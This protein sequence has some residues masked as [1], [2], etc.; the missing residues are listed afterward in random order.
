[1]YHV[2][3]RML[4]IR[5]SY[6]IAEIIIGTI[7]TSQLAGLSV[8]RFFQDFGRECATST[9]N[10]PHLPKS[11]NC[12]P[13]NQGTKS[14]NQW[15][16][17]LIS[18]S[19]K[20]LCYWRRKGKGRRLTSSYIQTLD[21]YYGLMGYLEVN[22]RQFV[23]RLFSNAICSSSRANKNSKFTKFH[24]L[25]G[26]LWAWVICQ[27]LSSLSWWEDNLFICN[28]CPILVLPDWTT[29]HHVIKMCSKCK[30]LF[31]NPFSIC[32]SSRAN[33]NTVFHMSRDTVGPNFD[34]KIWNY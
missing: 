23:S 7:I 2:T 32:G 24:F 27:D 20:P 18:S 14:G 17:R 3:D 1:M 29:S 12:L 4:L 19:W 28:S 16:N 25:G 9:Q 8:S 34:Q 30:K 33:K 21:I 13:P 22:F 26:E 10:L 5:G 11:D 31:C 6:R 15:D